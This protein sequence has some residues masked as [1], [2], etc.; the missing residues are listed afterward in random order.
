[1]GLSVKRNPRIRPAE[2]GLVLS[3]DEYMVGTST[4]DGMSYIGEKTVVY[5]L[6]DEDSISCIKELI[7]IYNEENKAQIA[8]ALLKSQRECSS[9]S[10]SS[11]Y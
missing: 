5:T 4:Y 10:I 9:P 7:S 8:A 11:K 3:Y 2:N 1:M 6:S